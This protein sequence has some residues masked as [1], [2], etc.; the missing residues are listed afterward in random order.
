M[1]VT[2]HDGVSDAMYLYYAKQFDVDKMVPSFVCCI[3]D[4]PV[5]VEPDEVLSHC[6]RAPRGRTGARDYVVNEHL[7]Q[8]ASL[9]TSP[10]HDCIPSERVDD[11]HGPGSLPDYYLFQCHSASQEEPS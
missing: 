7:I 11:G 8:L 3:D 1:D 10:P 9:S 2:S 4:N 5:Q 6:C